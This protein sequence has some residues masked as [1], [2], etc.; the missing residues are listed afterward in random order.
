[1]AM[2]SRTEKI[3]KKCIRSEDRQLYE[4]P[5]FSNL[6]RGAVIIPCIAQP[7]EVQI[8]I[9][10]WA[11]SI[12][13]TAPLMQVGRPSSTLTPQQHCADQ[14]GCH[15]TCRIM[16]I[17]NILLMC[18]GIW[19]FTIISFYST[20]PLIINKWVV[21]QWGRW[22]KLMGHPVFLIWLHTG[23]VEAGKCHFKQSLL[24]RCES[25]EVHSG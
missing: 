20:Y 16:R 11:S 25:H 22:G 7:T 15:L 2:H 6:A 1:M 24:M 4:L 13:G 5:L 19:K 3:M 14:C 23:M 8:V 17:K 9:L 12:T 21:I 18:N 10:K